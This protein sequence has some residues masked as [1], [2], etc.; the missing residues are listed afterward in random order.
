MLRSW[1]QIF[2]PALSGAEEAVYDNAIKEGKQ[3]DGMH[4][5]CV[6]IEGPNT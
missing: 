3:L 4:G 2:W 1:R 6:I 5:A